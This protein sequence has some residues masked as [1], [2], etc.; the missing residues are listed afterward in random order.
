MSFVITMGISSTCNAC[1]LTSAELDE[2]LER[3]QQQGESIFQ[4]TNSEFRINLPKALGEG[5]DRIV[6]LR[7]GLTLLVR[8]ATLWHTTRM[9][10]QHPPEFPLTAKFYLSG[11]SRV[12]TQGV[13]G[14]SPIAGV[15]SEYEEQA[16]Y[17]YLYHL[18]DLVEIEEWQAQKPTQVIM[19]Y[20]EADYFQ[21]FNLSEN[22][23]PDPLRVFMQA[24]KERSGFAQRFHQPLGKVTPAMHQ[25]LQQILHCPY[26]G[27]MQQFYLESKALELLT[28]QFECWKAGGSLAGQNSSKEL[29]LRSDDLERLH[30]AKAILIARS[31]EPPSLVQL[32]RQVGLND[33]KLKQGFRQ[34]FGTTVF[35]YLQ[36]YRMQ[37]AKQLLHD[38]D[39]SIASVATTV[40][41]KNPEAFS[42]AFRRKFAI[43]PKSYQIGQ[44]I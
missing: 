18:P 44:R 38:S 40:G 31:A 10:Q 43:S 41:Y 5:G 24:Q 15:R 36:D 25:L 1:T 21:N 4:Q 14:A 2:L 9:E 26:R 16:G 27:L 13:L 23:L 3:A 20:A 37:Q 12:Q 30:Q 28:L 22:R 34:V 8:D 32:A 33:R 29:L 6:Y 17:H 42:T 11:S 35:G 39:L 7:G 19:I